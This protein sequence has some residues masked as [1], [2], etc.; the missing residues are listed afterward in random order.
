MGARAERGEEVDDVV[1]VV[2]EVEAPV[3]ERNLA[4]VDP[5]GDR[6]VVARQERRDRVAQQ[7][8]VVAGHRRD[9]EQA[10]LVRARAQLAE[11]AQLGEGPARH[12]LLAHLDRL[13][14]DHDMADAEARLAVAAR[15]ALEDLAAGGDRAAHARVRRGHERMAEDM[16]QRLRHQAGRR[17]H[18]AVQV[19]EMV[20]QVGSSP[21]GGNAH[22]IAG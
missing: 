22:T 14:V 5:V 6:H 17:D 12:H 4:G 7:R 18:G 11:A 1:D 2:V 19:V 21:H 16:V 10:R 3:L 15:R 9:D 20:E 8:R 13:A